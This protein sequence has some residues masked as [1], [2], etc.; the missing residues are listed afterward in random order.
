MRVWWGMEPYQRQQFDYLLLTATERFVDRVVQR[1]AGHQ[2]ALDRLRADPQGEGI[3]LDS[4]VGAL[5][6]DFLLDNPAGACFVLQALARRRVRPP[7]P[8]PVEVML[9]QMA[10]GAFAELLRLK[11]EESIEQQLSYQ[12]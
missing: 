7:D 2:P 10:V 9:Q 11:A 8:G 12:G 5:F 6:Q 1:C 4:F 3:W